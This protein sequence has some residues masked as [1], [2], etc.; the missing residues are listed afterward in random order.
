MTHH[1]AGSRVRKGGF[2]PVRLAAAG[3][4]LLAVVAVVG[5]SLSLRQ[6]PP[7]TDAMADMQPAAAVYVGRKGEAE[8]ATALRHASEQAAATPAPARVAAAKPAIDGKA[9]YDG[10]CFACHTSGVGNAPMLERAHWGKRLAQGKD[11]LYRHAI[12]GY[13]GPDGGMMPPKGGNPSLSD[14]EIRASVDWMLGNLK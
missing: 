4:A 12:D 7:A 14:A 10:L 5:G 13:T 2:D 9:V 6:M 1:F 8:R 11:V 3:L